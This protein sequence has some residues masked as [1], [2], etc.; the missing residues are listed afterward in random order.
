MT[1]RESIGLGFF[2]AGCACLVVAVWP[3]PELAEVFKS[4]EPAKR[5]AYA[6]ASTPSIIARWT[7]GGDA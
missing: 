4:P 2:A 5:R 1:L 3:E 6:V 7:K